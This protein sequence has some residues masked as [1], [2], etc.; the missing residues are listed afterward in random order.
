MPVRF[1][2]LAAI[3]WQSLTLVASAQFKSGDPGGPKVG[4]KSQVC[5]WR[6]G[7]IIKAAGGPCRGMSGYVPVP[8]EWPDQEA[9]VIG[10]EVSP[11]VK[12]NY[13]IVDGG[14]KIMTVKVGHL[15]ANQEV[16]AIVTIEVRRTVVLP[17]ENTDVYVLPEVK[18]LSAD[19]RRYLAPSV[20]IECRDAKFHDLA[21]EIGADKTKAW[22]K[23]EA[24]YDWVRE[25]IK[26]QDQGGVMKG[27]L[28][29]LRDSSG[30]CEARTSVFIA[31]CRAADIPSRTVWVYGH[32]YPE[33]YLWDEKGEG[34]WF[35]CQSRGARQ[36]GGMTD[37]R[38]ILQKG[39][40]FR[41]PRN[42]KEHQR[43]LA[44]SLTGSPMPGG[45]KPQ[46]T[47]VREMTPQS[48]K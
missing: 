15:T 43:L 11:G 18:K 26:D 21:K 6:A 23:V 46:V 7:M 37:L 29:A 30:D 25:H 28:G 35:P 19:V 42:R 16:K 2:L 5:H 39:D 44:E 38:P 12:V 32:V 17:P 40:D 31:I 48:N 4:E 9:R 22:E 34:H 14:A 47:W 33:F 24:I 27:A 1:L 10:E 36:F 8:G 20:K 41:P 45:G 3:V 13:E